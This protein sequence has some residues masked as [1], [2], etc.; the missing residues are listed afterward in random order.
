MTPL[1]RFGLAWIAGI[2][3]AR[4]LNPPWFIIILGALPA[5]GALFLYRQSPR[6]R[7]WAVLA[8]ALLLGAFRFLF[9]QPVFDKNDLAFYNDTP[10]LV[11]ITGLVVDE[12]DVRDNYLN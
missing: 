12:P 10:P 3:L 6:T 5:L 9:F 1:I 11:K 8:L 7:Q 2:A 4:W